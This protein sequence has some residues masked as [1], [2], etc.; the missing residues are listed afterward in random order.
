MEDLRPSEEE[1]LVRSVLRLNAQILGLVL[2][3]LMGLALFVATI[4]LVIKGGHYSASGEYIVGPNLQLLS[5]FFPGYS[6]SVQ[7]SFVGL[8]YGFGVGIIGGAV[9]GWIYNKI[10]FFRNR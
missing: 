5:Q 2:G 1:R 7:G 9:I 3:L 10:V 4:W 6:V 8:A